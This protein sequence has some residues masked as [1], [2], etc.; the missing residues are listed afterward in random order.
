MPVTATSVF[1]T[2]DDQHRYKLQW[3]F[4]LLQH[5]YSLYDHYMSCLVTD[6][7]RH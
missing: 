1:G 7:L 6:L 5:E 4:N 3:K 2:D